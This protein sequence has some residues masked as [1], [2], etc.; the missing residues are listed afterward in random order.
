M[1]IWRKLALGAL[2]LPLCTA[3]IANNEKQIPVTDETFTCLSDMKPVRGFF[4]GNLLG[5]LEATVKVAESAEGGRYP[6]GSIVQLVPTEAMI[7]HREGWNP[8][9]NDWEFVELTVSE[10]G[11]KINV[12]GV[13]DVVNRFGG[14]CFACHQAAEAKWDLICEKNRGCAPLPLTV[15]RITAIQKADPRCKKPATAQAETETRSTATSAVSAT[16]AR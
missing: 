16:T 10:A 14:N 5:D 3:T 4:V 15:E 2:L 1:T 7:K 6:P 12:R 9:T 11:S 8:A 13:A